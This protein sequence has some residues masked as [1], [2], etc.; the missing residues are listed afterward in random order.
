[1]G[2]ELYSVVVVFSEK[3]ITYIEGVK[4]DEFFYFNYVSDHLQIGVRVFYI[5]NGF[6]HFELFESVERYSDKNVFP[7]GKKEWHTHSIGSFGIPINEPILFEGLIIDGEIGELHHHC[8][9]EFSNAPINI[10]SLIRRLGAVHTNGYFINSEQ[11]VAKLRTKNRIEEFKEL[12]FFCDNDSK[13]YDSTRQLEI[14]TRVYQE[15]FESKKVPQQDTLIIVE[16]NPTLTTAK[17]FVDYEKKVA[18]LNFANPVE[19]GGGIMRGANAQEEYLCRYTN[20]YKSLISKKAENYYSVNNMIR[21]GNQFNSMFIGTDQVIYSPNVTVLKKF[22][23][24]EKWSGSYREMY[25]DNFYTLDVLTCAAPFF[26]GSGYILPNGDLKYLLKRRIKNIFEVAIENDV[27]VLVLGAFGCGAFHN[28]PEVVAD[29]F[30]ECLNESRDSCAFDEVV[31]AIKREAT[32]SKNIRAFK[33]AFSNKPTNIVEY[34]RFGSFPF[35]SFHVDGK[36][37]DISEYENYLKE[38][39][40]NPKIKEKLNVGDKVRLQGRDYTVVIKYVD[41]VCKGIGKVDYAGKREDGKDPTLLS[42]FNQCDIEAVIEKRN[43]F[44]GMVGKHK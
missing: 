14:N 7:I 26:S 6:I 42:V 1:M 23:V 13:L 11:V 3:L 38:R 25:A 15:S 30:K 24:I 39:D 35:S 28:P 9:I 17:R 40:K 10:D 29:A 19:P 5:I 18:V 2:K 33:E 27:D 31:F 16:E 37:Y 20:L 44:N 8:C 22:D 12:M 36:T 32:P 43:N 34:D 21:S 41:Y 4:R